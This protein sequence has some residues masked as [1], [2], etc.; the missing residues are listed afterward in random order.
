VQDKF[1]K[2]HCQGKIQILDYSHISEPAKST[3]QEIVLRSHWRVMTIRI[4]PDMGREAPLKQ[5]RHCGNGLVR[6]FGL[7]PVQIVVNG[8]TIRELE[9][10]VLNEDHLYLRA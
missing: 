9:H 2:R 8:I 3:S 5:I 6:F 4:R 7:D 10:P 1:I